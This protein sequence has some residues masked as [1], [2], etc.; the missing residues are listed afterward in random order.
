MPHTVDTS[1]VLLGSTRLRLQPWEG[2]GVIVDG[3]DGLPEGTR[4]AY[5]DAILAEAESREAFFSW[6]DRVGLVVCRNLE[7]D[8][9]PYRRVGG[10]HTHGRLSQG[11]YFHHD[12]CSTPTRPRV[13]EIRCPPQ[14]FVRS[15][16]TATAPF[17]DVAVAMLREL[18]VGLRRLDQLAGWRTALVAGEPL[19]VDWE[20]VQGTINRAIR[21]LPAETARG[22]FRDVDR[23]AGAFVA[24]WTLGESRFMA[25]ENPARTVQHR[26]ALHP[27][28]QPGMPNGHLLKR[29]PAEEI[30][31]DGAPFEAPLLSCA[32]GSTSA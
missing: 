31:E 10:R 1:S 27:P 29:W 28:W 14:E 32:L 21:Q 2:F 19:E 15:M 12:G 26:R 5:L 3:P 16:R 13:V 23:A 9:T 25:N 6:V 8:P 4:S 7:I 17:P 18:P 24:P 30:G 22:W 20:V 11:E